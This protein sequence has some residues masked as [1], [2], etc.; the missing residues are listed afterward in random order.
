MMLLE[1]ELVWTVAGAVEVV[2]A[3]IAAIVVGVVVDGGV[4]DDVR[5][6]VLFFYSVGPDLNCCGTAILLL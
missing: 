1:D 3:A 6:S 4:G 5:W 2:V